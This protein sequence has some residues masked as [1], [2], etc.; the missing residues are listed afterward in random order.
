MAR[1]GSPTTSTGWGTPTNQVTGIGVGTTTI[2]PWSGTPLVPVV[3]TPYHGLQSASGLRSKPVRLTTYQKAIS[4]ARDLSAPKGDDKVPWVRTT[5]DN[6]IATMGHLRP[7]HAGRPIGWALR[8]LLCTPTDSSY[9]GGKEATSE[10]AAGLFYNVP[11]VPKR[12]KRRVRTS[13]PALQLLDHYAEK[14]P[15]FKP[16]VTAY[17]TEKAR[18]QI[19]SECIDLAM[20]L[21]PVRFRK[22]AKKK[23]EMLEKIAAEQAAARAK[24][25]AEAAAAAQAQ[26]YASVRQY[27][28]TMAHSQHYADMLNRQNILLQQ[29]LMGNRVAQSGLN[30]LFGNK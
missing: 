13:Y 26:Y 1:F 17:V 20:G 11:F 6:L 24:A 27:E 18:Q 4:A 3:N 12:Q 15:S 23:E 19:M 29:E 10:W 16:F 21:T 30:K 5:G 28:Q 22:L 25:L 14:W 7:I 8:L 2:P 9:R